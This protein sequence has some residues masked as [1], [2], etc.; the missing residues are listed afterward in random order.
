MFGCADLLLQFYPHRNPCCVTNQL[1]MHVSMRVQMPAPR[2][3]SS[4]MS[5]P[6]N[7]S[8]GSLATPAQASSL[9]VEVHFEVQYGCEFGQHLSIIGTPQGWQTS[10]AAAMTWSEGNVWKAVLSVPVG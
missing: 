4:S 7:S 2:Q 1:N 10:A 9:Q 5:Q 3:R 6:D 8:S